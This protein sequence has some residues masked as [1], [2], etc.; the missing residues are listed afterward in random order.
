MLYNPSLTVLPHAIK[1]CHFL[2]LFLKCCDYCYYD[3]VTH[4]SD[5][6]HGGNFMKLLRQEKKGDNKGERFCLWLR[7]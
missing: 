7:A 6:I 1:F 5:T 2:K 3:V 4:F